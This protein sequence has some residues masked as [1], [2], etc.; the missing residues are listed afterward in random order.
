M[1]IDPIRRPTDEMMLRVGKYLETQNK[2]L[3]IYENFVNTDNGLNVL[4]NLFKKQVRDPALYFDQKYTKNKVQ[5]IQELLKSKNQF[6]TDANVIL[7]NV[8]K[9]TNQFQN[10]VI[11]YRQRVVK[12]KYI[13]HRKLS[14]MSAGAKQCLSQTLLTLCELIGQ[15][16]NAFQNL[17]KESIREST[18]LHRYKR[19]NTKVDQINEKLTDIIINATKEYDQLI[20]C[21]E[22]IIKSLI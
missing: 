16:Y 10:D 15:R 14:Q 2:F 5:Q 8:F 19:K 4:Y 7:D 1:E 6:E 20:N 22:G 17:I 9:N 18:L 11:N 12:S 13:T 3:S 21:L